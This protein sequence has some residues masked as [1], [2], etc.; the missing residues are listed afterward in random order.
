MVGAPRSP[1][2]RVSFSFLNSPEPWCLCVLCANPATQCCRLR[3]GS[4]ISV[5]SVAL[6]ESLDAPSRI[7]LPDPQR[8]HRQERGCR[9]I[10][11]EVLKDYVARF[12]RDGFLHV[13]N[14]LTKDELALHGA[15]VDEAVATRKRFDTRS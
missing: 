5:I 3:C 11:R 1:R 7:A 8:Q 14:V 6:C 10:D 2:L 13:P 9:M 4:V 12:R 15:A